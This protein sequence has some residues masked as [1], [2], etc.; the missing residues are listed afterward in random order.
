M[1]HLLAIRRER[2]ATPRE[3]PHDATQ[4]PRAARPSASGGT[5]TLTLPKNE[6]D[7]RTSLG[8]RRGEQQSCGSRSGA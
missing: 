8:Q 2:V 5:I 4:Y 6:P 3:R 7:P 1:A